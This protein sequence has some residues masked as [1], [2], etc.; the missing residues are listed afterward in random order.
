MVG[1]SCD[2]YT[3]TLVY[4]AP[5][6]EEKLVNIENLNKKQD[7]DNAKGDMTGL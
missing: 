4:M 2:A 7:I 3:T 6:A 1:V 5:G